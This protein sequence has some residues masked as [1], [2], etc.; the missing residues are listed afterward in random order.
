MR[1]QGEEGLRQASGFSC[2]IDRPAIQTKKLVEGSTEDIAHAV[3]RVLIT[4]ASGK[5]DKMAEGKS[6]AD[7]KGRPRSNDYNDSSRSKNDR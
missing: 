3:T 7:P 4:A 5:A 1:C 2:L 6:G